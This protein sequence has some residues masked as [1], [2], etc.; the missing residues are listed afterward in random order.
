MGPKD[1]LF[2]RGMRLKTFNN[3]VLGHL[4]TISQARVAHSLEM[5][6]KGKFVWTLT[7]EQAWQN[8]K[9]LCS[10]QVKN[11]IFQPH[12]PLLLAVD[13]SAMERGI[14]L[15]QILPYQ[16][17]LR[18]VTCKSKLLTEA[19]RHKPPVAREADAVSYGIDVTEPY[20]LQSTALA[21][22]FSDMASI[23][24]V[25]R[26]NAFSNFLLELILK[27]SKFPNLHAVAV[28]GRTLFLPDKH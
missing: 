19:E 5:I 20:L 3:K 12:L 1:P 26:N 18:I 13:S 2:G 6:K 24:Y 14:F 15:F 21:N 16:I 11:F 25:G 28:P 10:L 4:P 23:Q 9:Y 27:I 7:H 17:D 22:I 8:I